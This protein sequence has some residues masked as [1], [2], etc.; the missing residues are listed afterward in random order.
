MTDY[1]KKKAKATQLIIKLFDEKVNENTIKLNLLSTYGFDK[2]F[3]EKV[4]TMLKKE[5]NENSNKS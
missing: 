4:L 3:V 2:L 1:Y 5:E